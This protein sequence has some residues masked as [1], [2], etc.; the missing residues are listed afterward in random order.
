MTS[1]SP[2]TSEPPSTAAI[3]T[4]TLAFTEPANALPSTT[5]VIDWPGTASSNCTFPFTFVPAT[6]M[7]VSKVVSLIGVR[8][9][10]PSMQRRMTSGSITAL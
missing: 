10:Q 9:R 5:S 3:R 1:L 2:V 6:T 4:L 7:T 8:L